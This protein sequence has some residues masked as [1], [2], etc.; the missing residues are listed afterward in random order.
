MPPK[1]AAIEPVGTRAHTKKQRTLNN[2]EPGLELS[3]Q[4]IDTI[5]NA[6][7][8]SMERRGLVTRPPADMVS[9]TSVIDNSIST[10]HVDASTTASN[11]QK[12]VQ[13]LF[14]RNNDQQMQSTSE[15]LPEE[16]RLYSTTLY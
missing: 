14:A 7:V 10:Q 8:I 15:M 16:S 2:D 11:I 5:V 13:T 4:S 3:Q 9:P 1:R 12:Q 6:V